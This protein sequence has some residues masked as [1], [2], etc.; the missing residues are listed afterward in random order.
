MENEKCF[1]HLNGYKVKDADARTS[2]EKLN[3]EVSLSNSNIALNKENIATNNEAI[4]NINLNLIEL[5]KNI[6]TNESNITVLQTSVTQVKTDNDINKEK[7]ENIT[8]TLD[9]IGEFAGG[10]AEVTAKMNANTN[11]IETLK[12]NV[13]N[14]RNVCIIESLPIGIMMAYGS[15]TNVPSNWLVCDGS[16]VSRE[17]YSDLFNV[18]GTSYGEGDGQ[19]T[20]NL[21]NKMGRVSVGL[22][23]NAE[24]FNAVGLKGGEKE[25][26]LTI[27]ELPQH[28]HDLKA[29][30]SYGSKAEGI[31]LGS[32]ST[33][34]YLTDAGMNRVG[35]NE[36]HNNLQPYEVDVWIIKALSSTTRLE[37][38]G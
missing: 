29:S 4:K 14:I 17:T 24:E 31:V 36:A 15:A 23:I 19:T 32:D 8:E 11:E 35:N 37:M 33:P 26:F 7:I 10:V 3:K 25:H 5:N 1:C 12:T 2:I 22:D 21:P 28:H 13:E 18:I 38:E 30:T 20:F 6:E 16:A 34:D 9:N 27:E